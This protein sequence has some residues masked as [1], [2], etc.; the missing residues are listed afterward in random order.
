MNAQK[1]PPINL[2]DRQALLIIENTNKRLRAELAAANARLKEVERALGD[3]AD[4]LRLAECYFEQ[5]GY[6]LSAKEMQMYANRADSAFTSPGS[7]GN[8]KSSSTNINAG[9]E[10]N[11]DQP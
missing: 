3:A 10:T 6:T 7:G 9:T 5:H 4:H 8:A 1:D 11:K 2:T